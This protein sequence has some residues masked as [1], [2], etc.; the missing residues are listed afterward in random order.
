[1]KNYLL[2]LPAIIVTTV[3]PTKYHETTSNNT[4]QQTKMPQLS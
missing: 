4:N 3:W 1:M 2:L